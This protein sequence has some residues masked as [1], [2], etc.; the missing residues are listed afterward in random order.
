MGKASAE[1]AGPS[2]PLAVLRA[3]GRSHPAILF[4]CLSSSSSTA[5]SHPWA[6]TVATWD[7][8]SS[9]PRIRTSPLSHLTHTLPEMAAARAL[10]PPASLRRC[11][12]LQERGQPLLQGHCRIP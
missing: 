10:S 9:G 4:P 7:L 11:H 12:R 6:A 8:P 1:A 3:H 5:T 2:P